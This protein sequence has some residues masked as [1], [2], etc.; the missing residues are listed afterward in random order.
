MPPIV[1][2]VPCGY[3]ATLLIASQRVPAS[4][5]RCR[6]QPDRLM[7]KALCFCR[8]NISWSVLIEDLVLLIVSPRL[9][10]MA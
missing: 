2:S 8:K 1:A 5:G 7:K 6:Q 10:T 9:L 4:T 3:F